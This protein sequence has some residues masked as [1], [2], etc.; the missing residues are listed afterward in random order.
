MEAL[1]HVLTDLGYT[2]PFLDQFRLEPR[3]DM[4]SDIL[5]WLV[6]Q[7]DPN[8]N[9]IIKCDTAATRKAFFT[10]VLGHLILLV[11][12][13]SKVNPVKLYAS[14]INCIRELLKIATF[15][16]S[17]YLTVDTKVQIGHSYNQKLDINAMRISCN[18]I[19][20]Q[21]SKVVLELE[22][23][24]VLEKAKQTVLTESID[25]SK[26]ST[27]II[28]E[29]QKLKVVNKQLI[30]Q[31]A[32]LEKEHLSI[33]SKLDNKLSEVERREDR[34]KTLEQTRPAYMDEYD[35]LNEEL[36]EL[37]SKYVTKSKNISWLESKYNDT[38]KI[39]DDG[40]SVHSNRDTDQSELNNLL[41][42][43]FKSQ[44]L[45]DTMEIDLLKPNTIQEE[46]D[47]SLF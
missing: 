2:V 17:C 38:I 44:D 5:L 32:F 19:A 20:T 24:H 18:D 16:K 15:V 34:L 22:S 42:E 13:L 47:E 27:H 30:E 7:I 25:L 12:I 33:S 39:P 40:S 46:D 37:Y 4:M 36:Q 6:L 28:E 23:H 11:P 3:F 29:T 1:E 35:K 14:D 10:Q 45:E 31:V 26:M 8:F 9:P 43:N 21:T 41:L